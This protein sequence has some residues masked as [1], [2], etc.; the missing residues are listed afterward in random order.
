MTS[1]RGSCASAGSGRIVLI[2]DNR[3]GG[4]GR[5]MRCRA[6]AVS[7]PMQRFVYNFGLSRRPNETQVVNYDATMLAMVGVKPLG[8]R[9]FHEGPKESMFRISWLIHDSSRGANSTS[10]AFSDLPA[11]M[12]EQSTARR[13][14]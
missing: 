6:E 14:R 7:S 12:S 13:G 3:L 4:V 5:G 9:Q 2:S 8:C 11:V 1:G 10:Q